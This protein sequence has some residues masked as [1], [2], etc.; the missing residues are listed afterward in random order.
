[1]ARFDYR[2][3]EQIA[4]DHGY[5]IDEGSYYGTNDDVA[6]TYYIDNR[7]SSM[8]DRRG[9]GYPTKRAAYEAMLEHIATMKYWEDEGAGN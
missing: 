4:Q 5:G 6:G 7:S 9:R 2:K 8:I 1:M 3:H